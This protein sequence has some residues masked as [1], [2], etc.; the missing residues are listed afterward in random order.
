MKKLL[1]KSMVVL[2]LLVSH[3]YHK[4]VQLPEP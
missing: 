1:L 3:A 2:L 4:A